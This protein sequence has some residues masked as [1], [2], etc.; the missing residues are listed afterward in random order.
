MYERRKEV[1][2]PRPLCWRHSAGVNAELCNGA[3]AADV[4]NIKAAVLVQHGALDT[5]LVE[6][7]PVYEEAL[8][9]ANV[10]HEGYLYPGARHES[11]NDATPER[12]DAAAATDAWVRTVDWSNRYV[13]T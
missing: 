2:S 13:R 5:R 10:N 7:W 4:P 8:I 6:A 3:A 12:Y 11:F 1:C 9:A